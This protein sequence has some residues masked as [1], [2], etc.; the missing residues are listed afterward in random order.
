MKKQ[1]TII[2]LFSS[3]IIAG[4][5]LGYGYM[6]YLSKKEALRLEQEHNNQVLLQAQEAKADNERK[7]NECVTT[8]ENYHDS[9]WNGSCKVFGS[10]IQY[11]DEQVYSKSAGKIITQKVI[12]HCSLPSYNADQINAKRDKDIENCVKLYS[13]NK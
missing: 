5:V 3:L 13:T 10:N 12:S 1:N 4:A 8:A 6:N 2:I 7:Y 9:W 11:E